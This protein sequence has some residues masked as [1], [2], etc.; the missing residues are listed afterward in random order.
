MIVIWDETRHVWHQGDQDGQWLNLGQ[1][2]PSQS[3]G[4]G[5]LPW[6]RRQNT[7]Q[8]IHSQVL[9]PSWKICDIDTRTVSKISIQI[10][11]SGLCAINFGHFLETISIWVIPAVFYCQ[12]Y[13]KLP[14]ENLILLSMSSFHFR[15]DFSWF[16]VW[17]IWG[18]ILVQFFRHKS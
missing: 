14:R 5:F 18:E 16:C 7:N 6:S 2:S 17:F 4:L 1:W 13:H 8:L 10:Q 11:R 12:I 15:A 9:L 3:F